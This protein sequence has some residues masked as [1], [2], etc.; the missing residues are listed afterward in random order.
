VRLPRTAQ[1]IVV[2]ILS[3]IQ[4][5]GSVLLT[6]VARALQ[7][8]IALRKTHMRLSR[9]LQRPEVEGVVQDNVLRLAAPQV[10]ER[11]RAGM[12]ARVESR[13]P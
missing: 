12:H 11:R 6:E 7:E 1:R 3:G 8:S 4:A 10:L 2:E 5:S 9:N 13:G